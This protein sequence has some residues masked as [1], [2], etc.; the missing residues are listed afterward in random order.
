MRAETGVTD[1]AMVSAQLK[2]RS[3]SPTAAKV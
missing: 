2:P 1:A 3:K